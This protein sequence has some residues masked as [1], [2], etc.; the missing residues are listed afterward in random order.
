MVTGSHTPPFGPHLDDG[1]FV[2]AV[3]FL[4]PHEGGFV[5]D[6][7]DPGGATNYGVSL[8]FA[9][10]CGDLDGDGLLDLD[11]DGDGDVD[12]DDI[13][14]ITRADAAYVYWLYWWRKYGYDTLHLTLATK[15]LDLS[16]NMGSTQAHRIVQRAARAHGH[17]LV[18]DGALGP[19]SR[20][21]FAQLANSDFLPAVRSEAAGFYRFLTAKF[22]ASEKYLSG[23]LNRAYA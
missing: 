14:K 23:W 4:W 3:N 13:R 5:D 7:D 11:F 19:K 21:V 1:R 9:R 15:L 10:S 2:A 17:Y 18:D 16:V 22:P 20:A 8:R 12:V 6:P